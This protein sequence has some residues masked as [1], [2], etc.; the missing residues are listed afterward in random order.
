MDIATV[1]GIVLSIVLVLSA[2]VLGG[3]PIM[4]VN[5]PSALIVVGGT[6]GVTLMRNP[7]AEV[8]GMLGVVSKAFTTKMPAAGGLIQEII[9]LAKNARKNGMLALE[10]AELEYGF[11]KKAVSLGVDG[12]ELDRIRS[13][14]ETEINSTAARHKQ[15]QQILMDMGAAA[16]AFGM[17][18]TLIGLVQMLA[19]LSDPS[20]IGPA[21]AVA[22]LTILYGALIANVVCLPLADKLKVRSKEEVIT[23]II[24]LEG[25]VGM[26]QGDNPNSIDQR[27]KAFIAPKLRDAPPKAQAEAPAEPEAVA[28]SDA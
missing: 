1:I 3:S 28:E 26:V 24:C 12:V 7:L 18:G 14:L 6:I 16:P 23:M 25:V 21:M 10:N 15:G 19:S 11:L 22:L 5:I 27:L 17:I 9:E 4:F 20:S 8:I 13:I 2:I